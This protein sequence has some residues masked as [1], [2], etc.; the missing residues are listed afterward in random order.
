MIAL[1][2][3]EVKPNI[4]VTKAF[5]VDLK[6]ERHGLGIVICDEAEPHI[7]HE[8]A[9][10]FRLIVDLNTDYVLAK[11]AAKEVPSTVKHIVAMEWKYNE[12][13][14]ITVEYYHYGWK[15]KKVTAAYY[16]SPHMKAEINAYMQFLFSGIDLEDYYTGVRAYGEEFVGKIKAGIIPDVF[17]EKQR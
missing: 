12:I 10:K 8:H 15:Q 1:R 14:E 17:V 16:T 3:M 2:D 6:Y 5:D 11:V 9:I 7:D 13:R 4:V